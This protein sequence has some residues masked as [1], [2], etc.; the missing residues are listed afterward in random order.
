MLD[1]ASFQCIERWL[2][3]L[4]LWKVNIRRSNPSELFRARLI[5]DLFIRVFPRMNVR[6]FE[7]LASNQVV[8]LFCQ[9]EFALKIERIMR[10]LHFFFL[11]QIGCQTG[12]FVVR[13]NFRVFV[14]GINNNGRVSFGITPPIAVR[15]YRTGHGAFAIGLTFAERHFRKKHGIRLV[16]GVGYILFSISLFK[17]FKNWKKNPKF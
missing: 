4:I 5:I 14:V 6:V 11:F 8:G 13:V 7:R 9:K 3:G 16:M 2:H 1:A 12:P 17:D 15:L 10:Q